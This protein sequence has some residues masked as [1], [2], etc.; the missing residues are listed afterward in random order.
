MLEEILYY[1]N[2]TYGIWQLARAKPVID[3]L[4]QI[5]ANI[6]NR[7]RNFLDTVRRGI[8]AFPD[9]PYVAMCKLAGCSLADLESEV[10]R[11]GLET[12]LNRLR[13][14]GVFLTHDEF[15]C[16]TPVVRAGRE[17][18][19]DRASFRNR[20]LPGHMRSVSSGSRSGG[21]Q[22]PQNLQE[23]LYREV[24]WF[25]L[26][27]EFQI[28]GSALGQLLAVLPSV[29]GVGGCIRTARAGSPVERWFSFSGTVRDSG[30]YRLATRFMVQVI[31]LAGLPAAAPVYLPAN[32]FAPVVQW[33]D[34]ERRKGRRCTIRTS[35]SAAVRVAAAAAKAGVDLGGAVFLVMGEAVTDAKRLA[36]EQV[37]GS[38]HP[39]YGS[40]ELGLVGHGCRHLRENAVHLF[41]DAL[42]VT[43][44]R[45]PAPR[46]DVLV[47]SL[48]F[49]NLLPHALHHFINVEMDDAGLVE[50]AACGCELA[51]A[52]Y[53]TV[54]RDIHSFG[55]LNGQGT[56][57][58]G[59]DLVRILEERLPRA[60]GG[61]PGDFQLVEK[62]GEHQTQLVLRVSPRL[63]LDSPAVARDAFLREIRHFAGGSPSAVMW[64]HSRAIDVEIVEPFLTRTGKVLSLH[65]LGD[66]GVKSNAS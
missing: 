36:I 14:A 55:K 16:K 62:E 22:T 6:E 56:T 12:T 5:R 59:T 25:V 48:L 40:T 9:H 39:S 42:A 18:P 65:L 23:R 52:G 4:G 24:R 60:L 7:E 58:L 1:S 15:K 2:M 32:D 3:P 21:T 35:P 19:T 29:G 51:K 44:W 38:I 43:Q 63:K 47:N 61:Q 34:S 53:S 11:H 50:P 64:R 27:R 8:F 45:H 13:E 54:I 30:H 41:H 31:R 57:L 46:T 33:I 37:N 26:D 10:P 66:K 20:I 17:I 28:R 49:T